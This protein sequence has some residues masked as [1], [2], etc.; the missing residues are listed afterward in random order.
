[1]QHKSEKIRELLEENKEGM[2]LMIGD[3][4]ARSGDRG[5]REWRAQ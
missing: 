5:R 4:I 3:F 2:E 1:M